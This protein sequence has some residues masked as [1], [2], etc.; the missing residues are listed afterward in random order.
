MQSCRGPCSRRTACIEQCSIQLC[1]GPCKTRA[2]LHRCGG[3]GGGELRT[4]YVVLCFCCWEARVV[5]SRSLDTLQQDCKWEQVNPK[6]ITADEL[7]GTIEKV[8]TTAVSCRFSCKCLS[9]EHT[10]RKKLCSHCKHCRRC[11]AVVTLQGEWK[12]G[13]VSVIMR[14]MS[15]ASRQR[16]PSECEEKIRASARERDRE[17][18]R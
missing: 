8:P 3:G 4:T 18:E 17:I 14:N 15:K 10:S 9:S 2:L 12:D 11:R 16:E 13:A 1:T 5:R 7:Y 6:A